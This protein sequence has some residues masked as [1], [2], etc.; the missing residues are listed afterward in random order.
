MTVVDKDL[1]KI[2]KHKRYLN[3][4]LICCDISYLPFKDRV[5]D[6]AI[7]YFTL[8]EINPLIHKKVLHEARRVSSK[9]MLV[10][11][12]PNGCIIYQQYAK[13]WRDAMHSIG[14]FEDYQTYHYWLRLIKNCGYK[15]IA[16]KRIKQNSEIPP[17]DLKKIFK[18]TIVTWK[19]LQVKDDY[20]NKLHDLLKQAVK[21][22]M[23]WSDLIMILGESIS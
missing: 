21:K 15:V 18:K 20:I 17:Q 6:F 1:N 5:A 23:K 22:G 7:F 14:K 4:N 9:I 2:M 16:I 3:A 13:I 12:S 11:P 8:H 10:E 19:K